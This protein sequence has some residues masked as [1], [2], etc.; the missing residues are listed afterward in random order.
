MAPFI[1]RFGTPS[2]AAFRLARS[3]GATAHTRSGKAHGGFQVKAAAATE[4]A[5]MRGAPGVPRGARRARGL[6]RLRGVCPG[7]LSLGGVA[8]C[9]CPCVPV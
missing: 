7:W 3:R 1:R 6:K 4:A 5:G 9:V 2:D 8:E